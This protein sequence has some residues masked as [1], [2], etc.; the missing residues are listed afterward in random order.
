MD[1]FEYVKILQEVILPY[2]QEEMLLKWMFQQDNDLKHNS[3]WAASSFQTNKINVMEW[4]V[5]S[6]DF[7]HILEGITKKMLFLRQN[8]EMQRN[9]GM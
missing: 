1:Q 4:L 5:Q 9:C 7:H 6:P 8:Q 2:V 3:K